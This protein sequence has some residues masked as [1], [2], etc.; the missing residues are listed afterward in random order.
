MGPVAGDG[1]AAFLQGR[2]GAGKWG[3]GRGRQRGFTLVELIVVLGIIAMIMLLAVPR[4]GNLAPGA[5]LRAAAE[6][7]R[8]DLRGVRNTALRE[9][10]ETVLV[11]DLETGTWRDA[12]GAVC[13]ALP[14]GM[15]L[16][17]T[18]ARQEQEG[19]TV[20]GVRFYPDGTSTGAKVT[21]SRD[22]RALVLS[23]DWF[24]GH[25]AIGAPDA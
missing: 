8:G 10:R 21:L 18:V 2:E 20:G 4:L 1:R 11:I 24:D 14:K 13:G 9:S 19:D 6:E 25:V 3:F 17:L 7:L 16:A 5:E 15:E 22:G 23:I 12:T